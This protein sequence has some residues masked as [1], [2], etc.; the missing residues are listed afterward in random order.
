MNDKQNRRLEIVSRI[1]DDIVERNTQ[2][3]VA[4]MWG[5]KRKKWIISAVSMAAALTLIATTVILLV[6]LLG[7]QVPIYTGMTVSNEAPAN[8]LWHSNSV[9]DFNAPGGVKGD[10]AGKGPVD[11]EKPFANGKKPIGD[12]A[13]D[14]L[15]VSGSNVALYYAKP[16][17]FIYITVH[18]ENPDNFEI[19]SFTLN[20]EKYSSY[21]FE[22]GSDMEN[23][24]LKVQIPADA[25]GVTSYT[26]DAIKYVDGE[27]IKDV[28]MDGERTVDIAVYIEEQ[29]TAVLSGETLDYNSITFSANIADTKGLLGM[30][31]SKLYAVLYDGDSLVATKELALGAQTVTFDG[32]KT[33]ALYQYAVI[34]VYDALDGVGVT[35]HV[36]SSKAVYTKYVVLF[37]AVEP[38]PY[39]VS[40]AM[41]WDEAVANKTLS[42]LALYQDESKVRDLAVTDTDVEGLTSN[43]EY[44]LVA[45]YQ[46][47][48]ATESIEIAFST[49]ISTVTFHNCGVTSSEPLLLGGEMPKPQRT[50]FTFVG[51]FTADG[52]Q[53]TSVPNESVSVFAK[54]AEEIDASALTYTVSGGKVTITSLRTSVAHLI[55]PAYIE[56]LPVAK[57]GENAF[58]E[59]DGL[60]S[61]HLPET[62][63]EIGTNAFKACTALTKVVLP[64]SLRVSGGRAFDGCTALTRVEYTGSFGDW[65]DI[66]FSHVYNSNPVQICKTLYIGGADVTEDM[67]AIPDSVTVIG[68]W[69]LAGFDGITEMVIPTNVQKMGYGALSGCDSLA[70]LSIPVLST[71]GNLGTS[72][73]YYDG[74]K[75]LFEIIPPIASAELFCDVPD[76]LTTV[77]VIGDLTEF[78]VYDY[79][80]PFYGFDNL[81]TVT[82]PDTLQSIGDYAFNGCSK[83]TTVNIP[84]GV[85][86]I[87]M[88]AFRYCSM[89]ENI[90]LP[91]GL[92]TIG[93]QAFNQCSA[94]TSINIPE[95]VTEIGMYAFL[96]AGLTS[97]HIPASMQLLDYS[98]FLLCESL[99]SVTFAAN[100]APIIGN[101][102]FAACSKLTELVIPATVTNIECG[103]FAGCASLEKLTMPLLATASCR[104][105][106]CMGRYHDQFR[107]FFTSEEGLNG[108][109]NPTAL[110]VTL[111]TGTAIPE[112]YFGDMTGIISVELP[113]AVTE[114]GYDAFYGCT[115]LKSVQL[116][117]GL[118]TIGGN[119]FRGCS[120][121]T[122]ISI[123]ESVTEVGMFAFYYGCTAL[124]S[125]DFATTEGWWYASSADATT[126]TALSSADL[127]ND[128][129]AAT[130]L[131]TDYAYFWWKRS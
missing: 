79:D 88:F 28:R 39:S 25:E 70:T 19:L 87:G 78:P 66:S 119:A 8:V 33:N 48:T 80:G 128:T 131:K 3:R 13:K 38:T 32:L 129:T 67:P 107:R 100:A 95:G 18:V 43:T 72:M 109:G 61:V 101:S 37:D 120:A 82:L 63:T 117:A 115:A 57:L 125:V 49:A 60:E 102:A 83:L 99:E 16:G 22:V 30:S 123:P 26:I 127:E 24:I 94:L 42:S 74:L 20:G 108:N 41:L 51:W 89:L 59:L 86:E 1:D 40:F 68:C 90:Q 53:I 84:A 112:R 73:E 126:G 6:T 65:F 71:S 50:G 62:M 124:T 104:S 15:S 96:E 69:A 44:R 118:Q 35:Q 130:Y 55:L 114:I 116:P 7:K 113:S 34:A 122:S 14:A 29:P 98:A 97:V 54:W 9:A 111:T 92:Q 10:H 27:K 64:K 77:H 36:L 11:Q 2:K 76:T 21:M 58:A 23:L 85:T 103:A 5:N 121:L 93:A 110:S 91:A 12:A 75:W 106:S 4:L 52:V 46:N 31:E 17:S 47:G 81:T 105:G 56:G 45:T